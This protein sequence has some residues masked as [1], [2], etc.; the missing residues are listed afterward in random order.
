MKH[1]FLYHKYIYIFS[2]TSEVP[3]TADAKKSASFIS[4]RSAVT[5]P[6][7]QLAQSLASL[8]GAQSEGGEL[9]S[10]GTG[11]IR[12]NR[13]CGWRSR[14]RPQL[15]VGHGT[16]DISIVGG[17]REASGWGSSDGYRH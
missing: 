2:T 12:H 15:A 7:Q 13:N 3:V 6:E 10:D 9:H 11:N 16:V 17:P 5:E 4:T 8:G 1:V 14:L